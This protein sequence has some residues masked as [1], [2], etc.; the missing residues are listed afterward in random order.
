MILLYGILTPWNKGAQ[1][2]KKGVQVDFQQVYQLQIPFA[3]VSQYFDNMVFLL[4]TTVIFC[5]SIFRNDFAL[6]LHIEHKSGCSYCPN[7]IARFS[8]AM[9]CGYRR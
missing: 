1:F 6:A 3:G 4:M 5:S 2:A 8:R 9:V 7:E